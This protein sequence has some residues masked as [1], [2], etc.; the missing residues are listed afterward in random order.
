MHITKK[1]YAEFKKMW[2][3]QAI[4]NGIS[5]ADF[6]REYFPA[7]RRRRIVQSQVDNYFE[8]FAGNDVYENESYRIEM[9]V[10]KD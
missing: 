5:E 10:E 3:L 7:Y 6:F 8:V 1:E 4:V 9:F 2:M